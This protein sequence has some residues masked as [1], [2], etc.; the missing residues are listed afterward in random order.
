M[1]LVAEH[2][3]HVG[4]ERQRSP[5]AG[6]MMPRRGSVKMLPRNTTWTLAREALAPPRGTSLLAMI[7][8][9]R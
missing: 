4:I 7:V 5:H 9:M 2:P 6:I 8:L 1:R 3:G